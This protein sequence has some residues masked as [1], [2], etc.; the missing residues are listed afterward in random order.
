LDYI[1]ALFAGWRAE[2]HER[3]FALSPVQS[4]LRQSV[5]VL[6]SH[7]MALTMVFRGGD[8]TNLRAAIHSAP[9]QT[10]TLKN[11]IAD[12]WV[13][14]ESGTSLPFTNPATGDI[15]GQV[16]LST[17]TD[18]DRAV[19]AA[20]AAFPKW[21]RVPPIDRARYMFKLRELMVEHSDEL[22]RL[23]TTEHGKTLSD[24]RG[25]VQRAIENVE[26]AAG[27][28]SL[29][30][31][32]TLED[33]AGRDIDESA[34]RRPLGVF[35][36]IAPFN[37]PLMVPFWFMP[38]A[39]ATGNT[40]IVKPSEQV[41]LSQQLVFELIDRLDLPSGVVNLVNGS[42][43]AVNA[44]LDHPD[45][46][47][48][49]FV[50]ST[51]T[52]RHVYGRAA[53]SGKRVQASGGAKNVIVVM[54]DAVMSQTIPNIVN[55]AFG[56][57]GQRCLAG[58]VVVPVGA[59]HLALRSA[60][61]D[62]MAAIRVGNGLDP[63]VSMGPVISEEAR[64]RILRAIENG[65]REGADLVAGGRAAVVRDCPDGY[66]VEPTLFDEVKPDME[67][68][69]SEIFGPVLAMMPVETLDEAIEFVNRSRYGNAASIFT[70]NGGW[71]REFQ[72]RTDVGNIGINI[73]VAAPMA[74]FPFGGAKESFFGDLHGQGRDAVDFFTDRRVVI[75]R[76]FAEDAAHAGSH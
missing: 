24:A 23:V 20:A 62:A 10:E 43:E 64:H 45:I 53:A 3:S 44:L 25:S 2:L 41:P 52:A 34:I 5:W 42:H 63:E 72:I 30:M 16:P 15:I 70:Q 75:T 22:A 37:F 38:Y 32:Q 61:L 6:I 13:A 60:L 47:G 33:G 65:K 26:V 4:T 50:G 67:L 54:P 73:G 71:A 55:S 28:P 21:R 59:A 76:W 68:A 18:V 51:S 1:W 56:S 27:M 31:G 19:R 46:R 14:S 8:V 48:I 66:F 40:I 69:Q 39:L 58:S 29:L 49:S 35:A 74:Y 57:S 17:S 11:Y 36:V 7:G 12:E 9:E